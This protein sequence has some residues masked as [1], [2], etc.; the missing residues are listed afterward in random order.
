MLTPALSPLRLAILSVHTSP[1]AA[2]G[3]KKTGGM[4]V[5]VREIARELARR[6]IL[7]DIYTRVAAP[8][9]AGKVLRLSKNARL[10]Y[11]PAGPQEVIGPN[12]VYMFL[13]EFRDA[14]EAFVAAE[15]I[16]YDAIYSHYWLSGW[17]ALQLKR[18]WGVPVA[19]MFHTL[20]R[21]KNRIAERDTSSE[22]DIRVRG[23]TQ[24]M[25]KVDRIIAATP[26]ERSQLL[27]LYRA[28]RRKISI[29]PPGVDLKRFSPGNKAQSMV[30][31][32][33]ASDVKHLLFVGRIE[34]LKA[35]DTIFQATAAL[36]SQQPTLYEQLRINIIG[37]DLEDA[38][39]EMQRLQHLSEQLA[40]Q[41]SVNFLGAQAQDILPDYYRAVEALIMP[42]DYESF[43]M[44]A[45]ESMA[46]GTPVIASEVGGLAFLIQDGVTG[47]HVPVR[48]PLALASRI[49]T[50]LTDHAKQASMGTSAAEVAKDY[51][52]SKITDQ[53]LEV[54]TML[55]TR[56][57]RLD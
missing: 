25:E 54:F 14:L 35:V 5:Y 49:T 47:Y 40:L 4:N 23:E 28:D 15:N 34:P 1:V 44:V 45:L 26:A 38:S 48:E 8:A 51:S 36:R 19:Q 53:L 7:I 9:E 13:N 37:G 57:R 17:V 32:G 52:W 2:L 6:G 55:G 11:L 12:D 27:Y 3:G 43:G 42:S 20:G 50:L 31:V 16:A 46:C 10:I 56:P 29:V 21:M 41:N 18:K 30:Q 39:A 33:L 22:D 24:I